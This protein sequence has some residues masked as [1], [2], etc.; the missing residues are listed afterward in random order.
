M[1]DQMPSAEALFALALVG[2][3]VLVAQLRGSSKNK[4]IR[5]Y[6]TLNHPCGL[7]DL[8]CI[9]HNALGRF[10]ELNQCE[11]LH[12]AHERSSVLRLGPQSPVFRR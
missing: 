3:A 9:V 11:I 6:K 5:R 8:A 10:Q 7:T 12:H 2:S 4:Y 1:L